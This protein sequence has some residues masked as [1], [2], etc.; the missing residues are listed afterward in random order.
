MVK[1]IAASGPQLDEQFILRFANPALAD[2]VRRALREEEPLS[3]P[4]A[5]KIEFTGRQRRPVQ[6]ER[7][8]HIL[9]SA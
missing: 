3:G 9:T 4:D 8:Q 6:S 7:K 2:R 5:L 1:K